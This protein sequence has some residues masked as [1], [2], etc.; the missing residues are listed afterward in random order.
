M[1]KSSDWAL[2]RL[3]EKKQHTVTQNR[4]VLKDGFM[5]AQC[6]D[7]FFNIIGIIG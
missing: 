4:M 7:A 2:T 5:Q 6:G 3:I 1:E